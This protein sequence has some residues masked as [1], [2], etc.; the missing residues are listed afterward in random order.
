MKSE[1]LKPTSIRTKMIQAGLE[2]V[3]KMSQLSGILRI[4]L[5]G[6]L[7]T[8]TRDPKDVDLLVSVDEDC[9]LAPL[10]TLSRK[11]LGRMQS[12]NR[13][14]DVFLANPAGEY[15]GRICI[16]KVCTPG[17]R[18]RCDALNCGQRSHLHDDFLDIQLNEKIIASP[19]LELWP[20]IVVRIAPLP[21]DLSVGLVKPLREALGL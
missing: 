1:E 7:T 11:L 8:E 20:K 9:D 6:S 12:L 2:T 16:W 13:G 15:I 3:V 17:I 5:L 21:S 14:A 10:A 4:A 18:M 19:P